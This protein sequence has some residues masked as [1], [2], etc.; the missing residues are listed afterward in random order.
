[1][2]PKLSALPHIFMPSY[3]M[4]Q[5][6]LAP[7]LA[8]GPGAVTQAASNAHPSTSSIFKGV[9]L[10]YRLSLSYH[11]SHRVYWRMRHAVYRIEASALVIKVTG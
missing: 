10:F 5:G 2:G 6:G 7:S 3:E 4:S 9:I 8:P 1:M 11:I